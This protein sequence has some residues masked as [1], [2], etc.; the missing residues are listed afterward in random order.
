MT[1]AFRGLYSA[2][3]DVSMSRNVF[4]ITKRTIVIQSVELPILRVTET[5]CLQLF[6][7]SL[8]INI[9]AILAIHLCLPAIDD[10]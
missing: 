1:K 6:R 5:R 4:V 7:F 9:L 2:G 3:D 10:V 8:A